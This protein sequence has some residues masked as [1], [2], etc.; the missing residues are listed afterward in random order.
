MTCIAALIDSGR[1]FM[2]GDS[3]A[4]DGWSLSTVSQPKVF[5]NGGFLIGYT[6]SFRM[7][8]LLQHAF[9]PPQPSQDRDLF[10]FMV[11]DF[12][13]AVR[14][15]FKAGGYARKIEDAEKAGTFLIGHAG[16][17]FAIQDDYQVVECHVPFAAC[18]C[19]A[20]VA[21][22]SLF[23]SR[24]RDPVARVHVAL[25]AAERFSAGVRGPFPILSLGSPA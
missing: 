12:V 5:L 6:S 14:A 7:G 20:D 17:L 22:G 24:G 15:C 13:D 11:T 4:V 16:R 3:A 10:G 23:S 19:G 2:G 1:I 25:E 8:Q 21:L 9:T 18:G